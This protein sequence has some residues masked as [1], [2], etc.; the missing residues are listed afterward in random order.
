MVDKNTLQVGNL[1][2]KPKGDNIQLILGDQKTTVPFK[3]LWSAV[4]VLS[5]GEYKAQMI[6]AAKEDRMVFSRKLRIRAAKDI[7]AGEEIV[8]WTEFDVKQ[9]I[10]ESI[11]EEN[12][13]KVIQP[14]ALSTPEPVAAESGAL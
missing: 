11:A 14:A 9:A 1:T 4:F 13:A 8:V 2:L 3:E 6:P 5:N 12:G 7:K 10:V